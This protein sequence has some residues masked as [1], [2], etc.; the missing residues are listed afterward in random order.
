MCDEG[1]MASKKFASGQ[2]KIKST[3]V[4]FGGEGQV[5][6]CSRTFPNQDGSSSMVA[7]SKGVRQ[8]GRRKTGSSSSPIKSAIFVIG[9][10]ER[11]LKKILF[12]T[13]QRQ[14]YPAL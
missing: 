4:S 1:F 7:C 2:S 6:E 10:G 11:K 8:V 9:E 14:F 13:R 12:Y 3:A 5:V